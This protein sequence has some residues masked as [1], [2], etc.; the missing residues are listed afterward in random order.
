MWRLWM[1]ER[2]PDSLRLRR[3]EARCDRV[4]AHAV[5]ADACGEGADQ[6]RH[7]ALGRGVRVEARAADERIDRARD[8]DRTRALAH[9]LTADVFEDVE[10]AGQMD[11]DHACPHVVL[12]LGQ[13][14]VLC[15][16]EVD[17]G[18]AVIEHVEA[19]KTL[20]G[21]RHDALDALGRRDVDMHRRRVLAD[22]C[23]D[24]LGAVEREVGDDDLRAVGRHRGRAGPPHPGAAADD[25][26]DLSVQSHR[27]SFAS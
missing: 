10:R 23:G 25:E 5:A 22:C 15:V 12:E 16:D 19:T 21:L 26:R 1:V 24:G 20:D 9:H 13:P 6:R 2:A 17:V 11:V 8:D 4:H 3:D 7:A 27:S 18:C 14:F